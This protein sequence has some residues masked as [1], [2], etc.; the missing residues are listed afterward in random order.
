M[1]ALAGLGAVLL[2]ALL[3]SAGVA[4]ACE[5]ATAPGG[6]AIWAEAVSLAAP[7]LAGL[8]I[9]GAW[10]LT[11]ESPDFGGFSGLVI[12]GDGAPRAPAFTAVT[13]R[14]Y[15]LEARF[16]P[17]NTACP[18]TAVRLLPLTDEAGRPLTGRARDAEALA[19]GVDG[20]LAIAFERRHRLSRSSAEGALD[21][22]RSTDA[23]RTLPDNGG[24][25]ALARLPSG[26]LLAIGEEPEPAG[27][28]MF[29]VALDGEIA[30]AGHLNLPPP[31]RVTGA[32]M[33]PDG[34]LW[35]VRRHFDRRIGVEILVEALPLAGVPALP[36]A[37]AAERRALF[38]P[39]SG[40]DNMEAIMV[41]QDAAGAVHVT[42]LSDDNFNTG[43]Q[44]T[45]LVDLRLTP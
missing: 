12:R 24:L 22:P 35:I 3:A 2:A 13:D 15:L 8:E 42:I 26:V 45:L 40:I 17:A 27:F 20:A 43:R 6:L 11:A 1:R 21:T 38:G 36:D 34:R 29:L 19:I 18:L 39:Q 32:D 16:T 28:P 4:R 31:H 25:E 44:R 37:A 30:P 41:W 23:I 5:D 33:G 9:A 10:A 7:E 14:G